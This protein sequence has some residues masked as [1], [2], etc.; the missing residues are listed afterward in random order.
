LG[1]FITNSFGHPD[2][3]QPYE[4]ILNTYADNAIPAANHV[5]SQPHSLFSQLHTTTMHILSFDNSPAMYRDL[6]TL[7]P[8]GI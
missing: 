6:K 7:P 5:F 8:G 4:E 3:D 2:W 1:D